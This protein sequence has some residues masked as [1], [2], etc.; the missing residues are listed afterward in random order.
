MLYLE[1]GAKFVT[2]DVIEEGINAG[3]K[4]IKNSRHISQNVVNG[5]HP[6]AV[7]LLG[8]AHID[9]KQAL[10]VIEAP[11]NEKCHNHCNCNGEKKESF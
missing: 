2:H 7:V 3:G 4:V 11:A 1:G 8:S 10:C 9:G 5:F 6:G